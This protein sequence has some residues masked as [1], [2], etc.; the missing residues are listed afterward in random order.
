MNKRLRKYGSFIFLIIVF[1]FMAFFR[2]DIE[3][4]DNEEKMTENYFE[5]HNGTDDTTEDD[6]ITSPE[7]DVGTES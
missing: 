5:R 6:L 7:E 1:A 4:T 2:H 3:L